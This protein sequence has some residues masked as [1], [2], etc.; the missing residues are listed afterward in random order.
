MV[1]TRPMQRYV[2]MFICRHYGVCVVCHGHS[3]LAM[4]DGCKQELAIATLDDKST[5]LCAASCAASALQAI[6]E[7][8]PK[9]CKRFAKALKGASSVRATYKALKGLRALDCKVG[10][11]AAQSC[12]SLT[13][14]TSGSIHEL[15]GK[16]K[17]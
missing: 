17:H 16:G 9:G 1:T 5:S 15:T 3:L 2:V 10:R 14:T 12:S 7:T 8:Y 13:Y 11:K 6:G 4:E